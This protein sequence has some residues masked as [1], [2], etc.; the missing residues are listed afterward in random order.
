MQGNEYQE[1]WAGYQDKADVQMAG[2]E[3]YGTAIGDQ[4]QVQK[5]RLD[6][7]LDDLEKAIKTLNA[8]AAS[9]VRRT[10]RIKRPAGP[11]TAGKNAA[12]IG[13]GL[14]GPVVSQLDG[15]TAQV[16]SITSSLQ[17]TINRLEI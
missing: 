7:A 9:V 2:L 4:Q 14:G 3:P 6:Q 17:D 1:K 5:P 10:D 15:M 13:R 8:V 11:E 16:Q 12:V